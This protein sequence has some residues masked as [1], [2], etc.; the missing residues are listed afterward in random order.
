MEDFQQQISPFEM[1]QTLGLDYSVSALIGG[2]VF[3]IIG[4]YLYR[5]GRREGHSPNVWVGVSLM[6]YPLFVTSSLFTW[7]IGTLLCGVA[8]YYWP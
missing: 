7:T 8:Y 2:T 1:M 4:I 3:G 6:V 5:K